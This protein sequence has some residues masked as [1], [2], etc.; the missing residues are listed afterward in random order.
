MEENKDSDVIEI[1]A[2]VGWSAKYVLMAVLAGVIV[3]VFVVT[4][5]N[6]S[7]GADINAEIDAIHLRDSIR[8]AEVYGKI[9]SIQKVNDERHVRDSIMLDS[10]ETS[11]VKIVYYRERL[12]KPQIGDIGQAKDQ[13]EYLIKTF[14][15]GK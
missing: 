4:L 1:S 7:V 6:S 2:T 10:I 5:I 9:D 13:H 12:S 15:I 14:P 8:T 11:R 3:T